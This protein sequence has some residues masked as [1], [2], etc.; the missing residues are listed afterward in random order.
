MSTDPIKAAEAIEQRRA[1]ERIQLIREL[2]SAADAE[3]EASAL[4]SHVRR[5]T[6]NLPD[7]LKSSADAALA[8]V[9]ELRTAARQHASKARKA[10]QN[11]GWNK[12][13]LVELG[14]LKQSRKRSSTAAESPE[15]TLVSEATGTS[16]DQTSPGTEV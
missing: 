15:P 8:A 3:A 5:A 6:A 1:D 13:E 9:Q 2:K 7:T 4:A 10:A 14:L 12:A 16:P 11:G